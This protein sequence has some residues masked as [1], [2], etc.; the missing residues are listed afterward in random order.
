MLQ[1]IDSDQS[2]KRQYLIQRLFEFWADSRELFFSKQ[3]CSYLFSYE[4]YDLVARQR[5]YYVLS[6]LMKLRL[7]VLVYACY[8]Y[9]WECLGPKKVPS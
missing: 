9:L 4:K 6:N 8:I 3:A 1:L 5:A 7:E 2:S